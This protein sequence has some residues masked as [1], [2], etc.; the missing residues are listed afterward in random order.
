MIR[1]IELPTRAEAPRAQRRPA[2][3]K[4][5]LSCVRSSRTSARAATKR[6]SS[7][8]ASSTVS[9]AIRRVVPRAGTRT[10]LLTQLS[11][12]FR[13]LSRLPQRTSA[14][15]PSC[16]CRRRNASSS[17]SRSARRTDRAA[18]RYGRGLHPRRPLSAAL[19]ADDDGDP[20]AGRGR[21]EHLRHDAKASRRDP[22]DGGPA[23]RHTRLSAS[24]A[25]TRSRP[26]R[27]GTETV[28]RADRIVGPGNIYVAAAK[29]LLAGEVGIDFIA[30]PTEI[31][32]I[33]ARRRARVDRRR[34]AR[35]SRARHRCLGDSAHH[36]ADAWRIESSAEIEKQLAIAADRADVARESIDRNSAIVLVR[37]DDEA[38]EISN[39]FAPEHLSI[40]RRQLCCRASGT[41][42]ASSSAPTVRKPR[43]IMP[44]VR[45]TCCRLPARRASAAASP[46]PTT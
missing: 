4:R 8:R 41:P 29:K 31:L 35:A 36:V 18:A 7:M 17:S 43:A 30:G 39:R 21:A 24:A 14:R 19:D 2:S 27:I 34:H 44:P 38:V 5:K 16:S 33:A 32:I 12:A 13:E 22:R 37:S 46:L 9:T 42:A 6:C 25:R 26:S 10:R 23:R 20:G 40:P 11:P 3:R 15:S 1:I 45:I 28:P